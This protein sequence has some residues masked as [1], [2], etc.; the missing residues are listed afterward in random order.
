[1]KGHT[2]LQRYVICGAYKYH[3][4]AFG[5]IFVLRSVAGST[6]RKFLRTRSYCERPNCVWTNV[7]FVQ[8]PPA[9]PC[10]PREKLQMRHNNFYE[11]YS[12]VA[13]YYSYFLSAPRDAS[14]FHFLFA[15]LTSRC[16]RKREKRKGERAEDKLAKI[17]KCHEVCVGIY[18]RRCTHDAFSLRLR[19]SFPFFLSLSPSL[20]LPSNHRL[21]SLPGA[22]FYVHTTTSNGSFAREYHRAAAYLQR[23]IISRRCTIC[24]PRELMLIRSSF[25]LR[26]EYLL[27]VIDIGRPCRIDGY[28]IHSNSRAQ[29][30]QRKPHLNMLIPYPGELY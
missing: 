17:R 5:Q 25:A 7:L 26:A 9:P 19:I 18:R 8:P 28:R 30:E 20:S 24:N 21:P 10:V 14:R 4:S 22:P 3:Q 11:E 12:L 27:I 2:L 6:A 13:V 16:A 1:M 23:S 15:S 29:K